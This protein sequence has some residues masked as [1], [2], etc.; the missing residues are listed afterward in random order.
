[1]AKGI[2]R[3]VEKVGP[4]LNKLLK[5]LWEYTDRVWYRKNRKY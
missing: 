5:P 3:F 1:M 4:V 2:S